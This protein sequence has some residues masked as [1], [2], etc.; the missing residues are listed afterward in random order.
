MK[1]EYG[2]HDDTYRLPER[3]RDALGAH[4]LIG[5][6]KQ[7]DDDVAKLV[8]KHRPRHGVCAYSMPGAGNTLED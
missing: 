2:H 8:Q 7:C 1:P 5:L 6:S 3:R 4:G